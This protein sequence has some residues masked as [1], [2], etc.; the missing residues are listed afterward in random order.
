MCWL[1]LLMLASSLRNTSHS[2]KVIGWVCSFQR[3]LNSIEHLTV[4]SD[5][6]RRRVGLDEMATQQTAS[7]VRFDIQPIS[8]IET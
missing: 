6:I 8:M 7:F 1:G 5:I 3:A 4:V 2:T